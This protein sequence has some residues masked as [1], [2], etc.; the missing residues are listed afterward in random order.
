MTHAEG[1]R[2]T[3]ALYRV[4]MRDFWGPN[5]ARAPRPA[6]PAGTVSR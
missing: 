5:S 6:H 1:A 2:F 4:V 3:A